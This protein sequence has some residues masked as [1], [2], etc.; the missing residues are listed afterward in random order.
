MVDLQTQRLSGSELLELIE[1]KVPTNLYVFNTQTGVSEF[2]S[3][4]VV[5]LLGY[6]KDEMNRFGDTL[7]AQLT[8]PE[9]IP[10]IQEQ[11]RAAAQLGDGEFSS[12]FEYRMKTKDGHWAWFGSLISVMDR[13]ERGRVRRIVGVSHPIHRRKIVEFELTKAKTQLEAVM[14]CAPVSIFGVDDARMILS[15]NK[16]AREILNIR[17]E[18]VPVRF[19]DDPIFA[20]RL[21]NTLGEDADPIARAMARETLDNEI[22]TIVSKGR[23]L[24]FVSF[25]CAPLMQELSGIQSI[26]A[27]EDVTEKETQRQQIERSHRLDALGQLTGGIAHDFNNLL[28]VI[29]YSM[30]VLSSGADPDKTTHAIE[31]AKKTVQK[32]TDLTSRLLAFAKRQPGANTS[33]NIRDFL[34]DF[35]HM[36]TRVIEESIRVEFEQSQRDLI[37]F[38]ELS[39]LENALLNLV[40]NSRDAIL[41]SGIGSRITVSARSVEDI[42]EDARLRGELGGTF[43]TGIAKG[44]DVSVDDTTAVRYID[45]AVSDDG[46]GMSEDIRQRAVDPFF[47]TKDKKDA[48]GLGLSSVYGFVRQANGELRIYSEPGQ[49]TTIRMLIPRANAQG[50]REGPVSHHSPS[51]GNGQRILLVED[52]ADLR[53]MMAEVLRMQ[54][55]HVLEAE[56]GSDALNLLNY[57]R[58]V[59]LLITD[60]VMPGGMDGFDLAKQAQAVQAGLP[61][62]YMSGFAGYIDESQMDVVAP[63]LRKPIPPAQM[64]EAIETAL[65]TA[66]V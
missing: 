31:I 11:L 21:G 17:P 10:I 56:S 1:S 38:C 57:E 16:T 5:R 26:I 20:D 64:A 61:V 22:F 63:V 37:A 19:P 50:E 44:A 9:D 51:R 6:T 7:V 41:S 45:L 33:V 2:N 66:Q 4:A 62:I 3:H 48:T 15:I 43:S 40:L 39:M 23:P 24:R 42:S 36:T 13:D 30:Q 12:P 55:F 32:G 65:E 18:D 25:S 52:E 34:R 14:E 29:D 8:H 28:A 27:M 59:D 53:A 58:S 35:E 46:P 60:I 49:G 54:G 47:S